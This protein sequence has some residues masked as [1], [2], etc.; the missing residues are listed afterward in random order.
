MREAVIGAADD[1]PLNA[2]DNLQ[3]RTREKFF[4]KCI[5]KPFKMLI[6][7]RLHGW[8]VPRLEPFSKSDQTG[9]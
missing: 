7:S 6:E 5:K 9:G 4:E 3:V 8:L 1:Q 2:S